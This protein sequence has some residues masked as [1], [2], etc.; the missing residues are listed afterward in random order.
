MSLVE[1]VKKKKEF[2]ELPDSIVEKALK[3]ND[4]VKSCRALLRK[5]FG[6]FLTNKVRGGKLS[7]EEML[8]SHISSSKRNYEDFYEKIFEGI[9]GI[10]SVIDLGC[11]ANGF[12]YK[13][14]KHEIGSVDYIGV[15]AA[16]QLVN[17]MNKYFEE[18]LYLAR[19][20]HEDLFE[21]DK[22]LGILKKQNKSRA[23]FL[24]QVVD[25]L[26]NLEKDFSKKFIE[27]I[28]K[29]CELLILTL[30]VFS[31]GGKIR[32]AVKR[33]WLVDFLEEIFV[34]EKDFEMDG[35]RIFVLTKR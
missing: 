13:F 15:E 21:A 11:G 1:E 9:K 29:E 5:Y 32:F 25:A 27:K 14:L 8:S 31:L 17:H 35:E 2:G 28:S 26:E 12:S 6:V 10:H 24:F 22:I 30:P 18:K 16:G 19:A 34:I 4:D 20:V 23:V 3:K 7:D 33:K